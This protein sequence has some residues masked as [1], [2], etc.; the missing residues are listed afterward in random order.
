M[1]CLRPGDEAGFPEEKQRFKDNQSKLTAE[2]EAAQTGQEQARQAVYLAFL[3]QIQPTAQPMDE[4]EDDW[5]KTREQW[6]RD[7]TVDTE[8]VLQ[9]ALAQAQAAGLGQIHVGR[10]LGALQSQPPQRA[11]G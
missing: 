7:A 11:L 8:G 2:I 10:S 1:V 3:R 4:E 6:E 5:E 9:R